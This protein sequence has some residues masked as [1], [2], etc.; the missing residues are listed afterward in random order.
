MKCSSLLFPI[1]FCAAT[2][3]Q[4]QTLAPPPPS[5][6][7]DITVEELGYHIGWLA[8]D[9]LEGRGTGSKGGELAVQYI[10]REFERYGL[11]PAGSDGYR[12]TF[13]AVTGVEMGR[14]NA[15]SIDIRGR[16]FSMVL[17]TDYTP[18]GFSESGNATSPLLFAG[19]GLNAPKLAYNDYES[20]DARGKIVLVAAGHPESD[21]PHSEFDA[22]A[23][24]RS[25]AMFAREAGAAALIIVTPD[26]DEPGK[27]A[28]DGSPQGG[29]IV[30]VNLSRKSAEPLFADE[31]LA[32]ILTRIDA[33]KKPASFVIDD[34]TAS[35]QV[36]V[37]FI[38]KSVSNV[39]GLIEGSDPVLRSELIVFG[40]HYD[41]LG[42]GQNGS[43][44]RGKEPMI[45]N[46]ADDNASGTAA[47]L[48]LAQLFASE[49]PKRSMLFLAFGAEE[50]GLLGSSNWVN[51]PTRPLK[52]IAVMV[53][54]DMLG[55]LPD[56]T[57]KINIQGV[58]TSP[59]FE[60]LVK[61]TNEAYDFELGLIPDGQGSSDHASFYRK[62]V[63]VLFFF[64]GLHT[65]YHRPSDDADKINLPG[66]KK[67]ARFIADVAR[68]IDQTPER[69][70]FVRVVIKEDRRVRGFNVYV[71]TIPDYGSTEVGFKITGTSPGSPA[72]KAGLKGGD[73][74]V[75]FGET[76]LKNI[77]DYMNALGLHKP[78]E[79]VVVK[80]Q[81]G[82]ETVTTT[83]HLVK[84]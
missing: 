60:A 80:V 34:V 18:Y 1:A 41:H 44:Y 58:G 77:Y 62:D 23:S 14:N 56:S 57:N 82:A 71:G 19:Y 4:A 67:A 16:R 7:N 26:S 30:V 24:V 38:R 20:I 22:I 32:S 68:T 3:L 74:I 73:L 83:V 49:P 12:Q 61:K 31:A 40:A 54:I 39:A 64:T 10:A 70:P 28:Y 2:L 36:D 81:R 42:W 17:A 69:P 45:H 65:D 59:G 33:V 84:K 78:G 50:M 75:Q 53:N 76:T 5:T 6:H 43:L 66:E 8:S 52:D 29:G 13:E 21:N 27:F 46:G 37:S 63:P 72:E 11:K 51:N 15:L 48:E 35:L 9:A 25:K 47:M 79:D 55:R